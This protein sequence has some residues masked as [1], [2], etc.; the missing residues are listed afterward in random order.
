MKLSAIVSILFSLSFSIYS[1]SAAVPSALPAT[2][3]TLEEFLSAAIEFSPN[4]KIAEEGMNI[5]NARKRQANG[6]LLPQVVARGSIS[7]NRQTDAR[8]VS[9]TFDGERYSL[10]LT[11][12]LFN[13]QAFAARRQAEYI[14]DQREAEYYGALA[15]LLTEVAER[16]F[17]VLQAEDALESIASEL[18][19]VNNQL[20]QIQS[21]YDRQLTR[22]T[23]LYQAQAS[24]A[25]VE[26]EQLKLQS[27]LAL[28]KEALYSS[29]GLT[30]GDLANLRED[31]VVPELENSINYWVNL[32]KENNHQIVAQEFAVKA[33]NKRIDE[34]RGAYMPQVNFIAQVQQTNLGFNNNFIDQ[35][36]TSY[37]GLDVTI[38][39]YAGGSN[40]AGVSEAASQHRIAQSELRIIELQASER[41]RSAYL[42]V[43]AAE[44]LI[45]AAQKL[46]DSTTLTS[47]AMQQGFELGAVTSVEVLN[48]LR[49]QFAAERDLQRAR[50]DHVKFLVFLKREA[51]L[52]NAED[53]VEVSS[54]LETPER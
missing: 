38:P 14:E 24:V 12:V 7:E 37:L 23:D 27:E 45:A 21:L 6:Q 29:T 49:D 31:A 47:Q 16:Y 50:Y 43:Q 4:L 33:A 25:A 44:T 42:Q 51:G 46:V 17:S 8:D 26:A 52:L 9:S 3:L 32:A 5:G 19:A 20:S 54:W 1:A 34:R 11:Q 48:A 39:L 53:M 40:K 41:V 35:N 15:V 36:D 10:Q 18:E 22:V 13:W 30:A 2:G 28:T